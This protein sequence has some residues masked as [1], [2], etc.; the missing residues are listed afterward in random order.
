MQKILSDFVTDK[1]LYF[2]P[3][4]EKQWFYWLGDK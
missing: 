4:N 2:R 3:C 1:D